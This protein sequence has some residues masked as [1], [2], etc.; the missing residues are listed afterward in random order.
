M[1]K[2]TN[3]STTVFRPLQVKKPYNKTLSNTLSF[4]TDRP[5]DIPTFKGTGKSA[6]GIVASGVLASGVLASGFLAAAAAVAAAVATASAVVGR[7]L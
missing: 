4:T 6:S 5:G 7:M 3:G 1:N 2:T